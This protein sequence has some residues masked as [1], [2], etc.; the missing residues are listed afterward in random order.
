MRDFGYIKRGVGVFFQTLFLSL[1]DVPLCLSL[2]CLS[3][4]FAFW[5]F[6]GLILLSSLSLSLSS[7][8]NMTFSYLSLIFWLFLVLTLLFSL[9][10]LILAFPNCFA[11]SYSSQTALLSTR[12]VLLFVKLLSWLALLS[13]LVSDLLFS[14]LLL[15][16][17][18]LAT[19]SR[20]G[21]L[22]KVTYHAPLSWVGS[23]VGLIF[24]WSW[25]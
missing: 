9:S 10:S 6:L 4:R 19:F 3:L 12:P 8:L 13:S 14:L 7:P 11:L 18:L 2:R 20:L 17:I 23:S 24:R 1:S 21:H 25:S 5:L 15:F 16:F 22:D